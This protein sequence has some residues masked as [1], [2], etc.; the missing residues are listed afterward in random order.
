MAKQLP[1]LEPSPSNTVT[2]Q[3]TRREHITPFSAWD[4]LTIGLLSKKHRRVRATNNG[5]A[6]GKGV[7]AIALT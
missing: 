1:A 4:T 3:L 2:F 5:E 7:Q 6:I